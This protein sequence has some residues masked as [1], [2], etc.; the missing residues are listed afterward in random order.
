MGL[1]LVLPVLC[2]R[3]PSYISFEKG[4]SLLGLTEATLL[5]AHVAPAQ[6]HRMEKDSPLAYVQ[7]WEFLVM[8]KCP[9]NGRE[10]VR[11]FLAWWV[12]VALVWP[13]TSSYP[14]SSQGKGDAGVQRT[15]AQQCEYSQLCGL[16]S[17]SYGPGRKALY[18]L[19]LNS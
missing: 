5:S 10:Q 18:I 1:R 14:S 12:A 16:F 17:L 19:D 3:L 11:T 2:Y 4:V 8:I 15:V 13:V 6:K 9:A 7:G